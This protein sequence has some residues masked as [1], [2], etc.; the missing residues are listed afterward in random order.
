MGLLDFIFEPPETYNQKAERRKNDNENWKVV[1]N[2]TKEE[3]EGK[4]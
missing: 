2:L 1:R 3:I 4:E